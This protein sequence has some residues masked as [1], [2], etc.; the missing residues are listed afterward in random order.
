VDNTDTGQDGAALKI[1][2]T[3]A[4][5]DSDAAYI[6]KSLQFNS[7]T[8]GE[9]VFDLKVW[10]G[11][12]FSNTSTFEMR[13]PPVVTGVSATTDNGTY[14]I[15]DT[16]SITV[17]FDKNVDVSG[18]PQLTLETGTTDRVASYESGTG[19]TL[20]FTYTV[21]D[22]DSSSDLDFA[23]TS[24]LALNSGTITDAA[25][26]ANAILTLPD[27]AATGSLGAN[28]ALVIDGIAPTDITPTFT[29]LLTLQPNGTSVGTLAA[30]D[31]TVSDT[32]TYALIADGVTP[33][34]S[35]G[36][37][38]FT[39]GGAGGNELIA[40][41]PASIPLG[42][43]HITVKVTDAAG[44]SYTEAL[45]VTV[46]DNTAPT[47]TNVPSAVQ[48][49]E[50]GTAAAL[51]NFTVGDAD[52][53]EL[54]LTLTASN[55][56]IG[57]LTDDDAS[58]AG[59]QLIGLAAA[60]N[61]ELAGA[62]FNASVA[63]PASISLSLTD[64]VV[65][66]PIT[67][68]YAMAGI[69][70]IPGSPF[71]LWQG[72]SG[73]DI[74]CASNRADSIEGG[75]GDDS[76]CGG[77]GADTL[78]GGTGADT[79]TG[80]DGND[81]YY[82][83][84]AGDVVRETNGNPST[85]GLDQ[86]N[87][88]LASYTLGANIENGRIL[89]TGAADLSGNSLNNLLYAGTGNNIINGGP[90]ID[91]VSYEFGAN[92]GVSVSLGL[93]SAQT[94]GGSGSDTLLNIEYLIGSSFADNLTGNGGANTL[95]GAA[96]N[97]TLSGAGGIDQLLGGLGNDSLDGGAGNDKLEGGAGADTLRGGDG[98]D[99]FVYK[100]ITE[101]GTGSDTWD[102]IADFAAGLDKIDLSAIDANTRA[103]A[104]GNQAFAAPVVG[105]AF[106]GSFVSTATLYFDRVNQVLYGNNDG[107]AQADFAIK[108]V[109]INTLAGTD[110][111]L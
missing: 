108:L 73:S 101:T 9:Y 41:T 91:T 80:G 33:A 87:S 98:S 88:S 24:A 54:T 20:T 79:M 38:Y 8:A 1:T 59:I 86:V 17:T 95:N 45:T 15:G 97:D 78:N 49:V 94:T 26:G 48:V 57:D 14:G 44:N 81:T 42:T 35:A 85:G 18:T 84:D 70:H 27:P 90:S 5:T 65:T 100:A 60:L 36:N 109:G 50:T 72:S 7:P 89:S 51:P 77:L 93:S 63:G 67:A 69:V 92:A 64:G 52:D 76:L 68:S 71:D 105:D 40:T 4:A 25:S 111:M 22:G 16:V 13:S 43:Q 74:I 56:S 61:T 11:L 53:N 99:V 62:T 12:A 83:D 32:F 110:L 21:Q 28:K 46:T 103:T 37:T 39:I 104:G 47:L 96:G 23:S 10:D 102:V 58:A 66:S 29:T 6:I 55:G 34:N 19:K 106:G 82:V 3:A 31:A 30:T 75:A 2:L 107:D